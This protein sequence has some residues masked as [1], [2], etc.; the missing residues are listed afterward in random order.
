MSNILASF[1]IPAYNASK[2]IVRCLDSIYR[3]PLNAEEF[4]VIVVDDCS[5]DNTIELVEWYAKN[6]T[7]ITLLRQPENHRQGAA[8]NRGV[9]I[10]KYS[11][12]R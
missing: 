6:R 5:I 9:L 10:A 8:R 1:I 3:L 4:E 12:C 2:T 11:I 7:N